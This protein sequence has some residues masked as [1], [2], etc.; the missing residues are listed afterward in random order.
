[1]KAA[2][3]MRPHE[4]PPAIKSSQPAPQTLR[5][6]CR[7]RDAGEQPAEESRGRESRGKAPGDKIGE[8]SGAFSRLDGQR[9]P[10]MWPCAGPLEGINPIVAQILIL[11]NDIGRVGV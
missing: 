3:R 11:M 10:I 5:V 6:P 2:G 1:M 7:E 9:W 4:C 8:V